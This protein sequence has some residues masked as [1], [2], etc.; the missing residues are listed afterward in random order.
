MVSD[1][2]ETV[3]ALTKDFTVFDREPLKEI[4]WIFLIRCWTSQRTVLERTG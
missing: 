4:P 3:P 1:L 2:S